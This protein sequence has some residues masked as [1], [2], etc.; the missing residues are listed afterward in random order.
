VETIVDRVEAADYKPWTLIS[1]IAVSSPFQEPLTAA[2]DP[3]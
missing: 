1:E 2:E 3:R